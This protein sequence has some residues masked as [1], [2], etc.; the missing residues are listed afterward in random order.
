MAVITDVRADDGKTLKDRMQNDTTWEM[1]G[2]MDALKKV[3]KRRIHWYEHV[4]RGKKNYVLRRPLA[5]QMD[6]RKSWIKAE[7]R[8]GNAKT[9]SART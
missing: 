2:V 9:A 4:I 6:G 1:V 7:K 8:R 3:Q 5:L